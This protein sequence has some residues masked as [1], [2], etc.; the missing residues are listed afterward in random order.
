MSEFL[1]GRKYWLRD[2]SDWRKVL[3]FSN[4][5]FC[6][7]VVCDKIGVLSCRHRDGARLGN[8]IKDNCDLIPEEYTEPSK[9]IDLSKPDCFLYAR[10]EGAFG[11]GD[12]SPV[13][14]E[15]EYEDN[16]LKNGWL[17]IPAFEVKE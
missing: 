13:M 1:V 2:K 5:G 14:T 11:D 7:M 9:P 10:M 16:T 6:S 12:L 15:K 3:S 17:K 8:N 4:E